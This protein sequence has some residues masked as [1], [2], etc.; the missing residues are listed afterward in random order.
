MIEK[1]MEQNGTDSPE[2]TK[3]GM[4]YST[5]CAYYGVP[6]RFQ[7]DF[8]DQG[9]TVHADIALELPETTALPMARVEAAKFSQEQIYAL[10]NALCGDTPMYLIPRVWDKAYYEQEI[11]ECQAQLALTTDEN[12][13]NS[14][15]DHI[16]LLKEQYAARSKQHRF[17]LLRR[18]TAN[19]GRGVRRN[20]R[21]EWHPNI[22]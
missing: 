11:L 14:L 9:V 6:E 5:L 8:T 2:S 18:H 22:Y 7:K 21:R 19:D 13:I 12:V 16:D 17:S 20:G 1:G 4:D 3:E 15:N 10:F